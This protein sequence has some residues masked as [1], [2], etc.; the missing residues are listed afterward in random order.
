MTALLG[1]PVH[2]CLQRLLVAQRSQRCGRGAAARPAR[3]PRRPRTPS[4][5]R[6]RRTRCTASASKRRVGVTPAAPRRCAEPAARRGR[7]SRPQSIAPASLSGQP[8]RDFASFD[9]ARASWTR[10]QLPQPEETMTSTAHPRHSQGPI[11]IGDAELDRAGGRRRRARHATAA[12]PTSLSNALTVAVDASPEATERASRGAPL[13]ARRCAPCAS[14]DSDDRVDAAAA[15]AALE[16]VRARSGVGRSRC[17]HR[18]HRRWRRQHLAHDHHHASVP[19]TRTPASG[20]SMPGRSSARSPR[21]SPTVLPG[22][23]KEVRRA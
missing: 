16:S 23:F 20:C 14:W 7:P 4:N 17:P 15:R 22:P 11:R 21:P 13:A 6:E 9:R 10:D 3:R 12:R 5:A 19:P 18:R 2:P 8:R 1:D